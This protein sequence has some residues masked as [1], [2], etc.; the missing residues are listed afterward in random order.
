[1]DEHHHNPSPA[2]PRSQQVGLGAADV[3]LLLRQARRAIEAGNVAGARALLRA[4]L[5]QKPGKQQAWR[6]LAEVAETPA[7]ERHALEQ[8]SLLGGPAS[9]QPEPRPRRSWP[10]LLA[11][12][13]VGVVL[14]GLLLWSLRDPAPHVGQSAAM[15]PSSAADPAPTNQP[16]ATIPPTAQATPTA[17]PAP[18]AT[19]TPPP[20]P[21]VQ[22]LGTLLSYDGWN[23]TLLR[24]EHAQILTNSLGEVQA[25]GRFALAL[26]AV[27][28]TTTT[29]RR[30]SPDMFALIDEQ[31][32]RYQPVAGASSAYLD[33]YGRGLHGD[34]ALEDQI[35]P[36][37]GMFSVPLLFDV[38]PNA[39]ELILT[40]GQD[41][42]QG[43]PVL[44]PTPAPP[45][46]GATPLAPT[47][48]A[49][50]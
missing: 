35:P 25:R 3:D 13:G 24:P 4:L 33:T 9:R 27:S 39:S 47:S 40:M 41:A 28:N 50:P 46:P 14:L 20:R 11:L 29:T 48:N 38:D 44:T 8:A 1:M 21:D 49:G 5:R 23:A 12:G 34:L 7:E 2:E 16:E 17:T 31:G 30:L 36:T 22:A 43:W 19:P 6:M 42:N 37:S 32:Q 15:P 18:T 45:A 26:L 10:L